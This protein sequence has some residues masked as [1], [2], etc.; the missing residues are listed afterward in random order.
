MIEEEIWK[1][2][3]GYEGLY[4]V[5]NLGRV[6]SLERFIIDERNRFYHLCSKILKLQQTRNGHYK[7][8]LTNEKKAKNFYVHRLVAEAFIPNP[9]NYPIINH[10]DEC[11]G[12]NSVDNLEWCDYKYNCNYGTRNKRMDEKISKVLYNNPKR[13]KPINQIDI[14]TNKVIKR[15][16]GA[17]EISR[18]LGYDRTNLCLCCKGKHFKNQIYH[19]FRWEYAD[20]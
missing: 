14:Q 7:I 18:T 15:W 9:F 6:K 3:K 13:C 5:S 20:D 19:G 16:F 1:D 11:P 2:I 12:N 10:K 4:Q 8:R 17:V